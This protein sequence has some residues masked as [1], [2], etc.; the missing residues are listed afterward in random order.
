MVGR[1]VTL[2]VLTGAALGVL[3]MLGLFVGDTTEYSLPD[4]AAILVIFLPLSRG[5]GAVTGLLEALVAVGSVLVLR[6]LVAD[7]VGRARVVAAT[8]AALPAL[9]LPALGLALLVA[10]PY[11][12][13]CAG[14]AGFWTRRVVGTPR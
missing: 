7:R 3:V 6:R 12:V 9:A 1:A 5:A 11:A 13:A 4:L 2:G 8:A 10:L 14:L